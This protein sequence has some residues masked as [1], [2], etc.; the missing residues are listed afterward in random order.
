MWEIPLDLKDFELPLSPISQMEFEDKTIANKICSPAALTAVLNYY[1]KKVTLA[2][3]VKAVYDE[4][5]KI[6]GTWP[7][8]TAVAA[9][10]AGEQ[11]DGTSR[12]LVISVMHLVEMASGM[13]DRSLECILPR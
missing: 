9:Q 6:Y 4:N 11:L 3:A 2:E 8:N 10:T 13:V 5:A 1:G 7:L 12:T